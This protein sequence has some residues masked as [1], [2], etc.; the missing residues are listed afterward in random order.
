MGLAMRTDFKLQYFDRKIIKRNWSKI[1]EK[2]LKR[3]G[4]LIRRIA[5]GSIRRGGKRKKA[6]RPGTPPRSHKQGKTPPFKMI[7]SVPERFETRVVVGMVGFTSGGR[8]R[9]KAPALAE[10]GGTAQR[11]VFVKAGRHRTKRGRLG[12]TRY[13][14]KVKTV[15][16]P[17]RPFMVPALDKAKPRLPRLWEGSLLKAKPL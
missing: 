12:R 10:H 14:P 8:S 6:S 1:N 13:K 5:R 4:L 11:R 7:F 9:D 3:S 17:A 15:R 16:Y 2:P